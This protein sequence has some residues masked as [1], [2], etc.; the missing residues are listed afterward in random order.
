VASIVTTPA[1]TANPSN[2]MWEF[3]R[4]E[5]APYPQRTELVGRMVLAATLTMIVAMAFRI[6]FGFE[7]AIMALFVSRESTQATLKS[8]LTMVL[9][10]LLGAIFVL[11]TAPF[12]T[13]GPIPHFIWIGVALFIVF[14]A[15]STV[16]SYVGVLL[17]SVVVV[18]AF[19][20]WDRAV[21]AESNVIDTL[22]LVWATLVGIMV[23]T[24]VELAF[25]HL[26]PGDN[27]IFTVTDRL[28]AV[29][30]VL[31][32]YAAGEPVS[33]IAQRQINRFAMLGTSLARRYSVRSGFNLPYV[34]QTGGVISLVGTLVDTTSS[35]T[36]L[37]ARPDERDRQ[38]AETLADKVAQVRN[39]F[40]ARQTPAQVSFKE[41]DPNA[42]GLPLLGELEQTVALIPQVFAAPAAEP[43]EGNTPTAGSFL[44]HDAFTNPAHLQFGIKGALAT[45]VCYV[46]YTA[47][48]WPGISTSAVTCVFTALTTIGAS[49]QKQVLRIG[50]AMI[51]GFV[52]GLGAQIFILPYVDSIVGFG[53]LFAAVTAISAWIMTASPRLSYLGVQ[54]ALAYYL[55][56]LQSF[57]FETSL[58]IG[59]DRVV[60]ILLGLFAM[61][62]IFDQ[63]WGSPAGVDMRR[64]FVASIRQ[65]AQLARVPDV[66]D[67]KQSIR[68]AY[69]LGQ[70]INSNFDQTRALADGVL[71]EF[72]SSRSADMAF[73]EQI[74]DWQPKLRA[75]FL[76]R[77]AAIRYRLEL[78]GFEL[79]PQM[80]AAQAEFD[81]ALSASLNDMA[82]RLEGKP[83]A[84]SDHLPAALDHLEEEAR[85]SGQDSSA[86]LRD[87]MALS[88]TAGQLAMDLAGSVD[89]QCR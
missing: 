40:L 2:W 36:Q 50:G 57:K 20:L 67:R 23:S 56:H 30:G 82:N 4:Q 74:K 29:E 35:L 16:N 77:G 45:M 89:G 39:E 63:L 79:P 65:L 38:R 34:A 24:V 27:V 10:T 12:F 78:P 5:L 75:L 42:D 19:P 37:A 43:D 47:V 52:F 48:D 8:A 51:G 14:F 49:R 70:T 26:R 31:R 44:A 73:R 33:A 83:V 18:V 85:A 41:A 60:G 55:I 86:H 68:R 11:A 9:A 59:R 58:V 69:A 15:L 64:T 84:A 54:L 72:G 87:F 13:I 88:R 32:C 28:A 17:F 7:G 76:L 53:I 46:F 66:S 21:T 61:W 3:L 25:A 80:G 71:F 1:V 6:P 81:S 22:W 62:L